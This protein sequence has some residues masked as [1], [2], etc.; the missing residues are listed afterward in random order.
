MAVIVTGN[1]AQALLGNLVEITSDGSVT[2]ALHKYR[3]LISILAS[4]SGA[5]GSSHTVAGAINVLV[6]NSQSLASV[7]D[8]A[9]ILHRTMVGITAESD[10]KL[11]TVLAGVALSGG[12]GAA[13]GATISINVLN[14]LTEATIGQSA[15]IK[16]TG[17]SVLVQAFIQ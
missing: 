2:V 4:A 15:V 1:K 7:G 12:S 14:R 16:S 6:S 11:V 5:T 17:G 8:Y 10:S 13:V 3:K 9:I